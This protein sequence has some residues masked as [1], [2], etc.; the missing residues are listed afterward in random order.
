MAKKPTRAQERQRLL[1]EAAAVH[2]PSSCDVA[3]IGGGAAGLVAAITA[4]EAGAQTVVFEKD[5]SC[6]RRILA[7][8]NGRCN[9]A[10]IRLD[11]RRFN[12]P[13]FVEAVCGDRWLDDVLAFFRTCNMRWYLEGDRLYPQ[14]RQAASVRNVLLARARE[15]GVI[16]APAREVADVSYVDAG[17]Y[18]A[19][20]AFY[21]PLDTSGALTLPAARTVVLATGGEAFPF[22]GNLGL[23][24]THRQPVLCPL[25]CEASPLAALDGR[26]V[27]AQARL[28]KSGSF[29]PSW[30]ERGEVLFRDYGI[31]GIVTFDLSRRAE[32]G[33]LVELDL[34]PDVNAS[35][36]RQIVD[37][38]ARG[39]FTPGILDGLLDPAIA[40]LLERLAHERW[41]VAWPER[42]EA[43]S[44][45]DALMRLAKA[46]PLVVT[47]P[48]DP[49]QAQVTRG[50]L[51]N[52]QF[53]TA[54]LSSHEHPW[55]FACGEALDVDADCGGF[56][57][58]WAW[59]SG[60]VAGAAAAERARA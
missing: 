59:K 18:P 14:S 36:L 29:F 11:S 24:S 55:L 26:R 51:R 49:A 60:M 37:P 52:D 40:A 8:G 9:F 20:L 12:D 50:G 45:S 30:Q 22:I 10:N 25:A 7:T 23:H 42:K 21:E 4:A 27:H 54:T 32:P 41:H 28:T 1:E 3:I 44:D 16:L 39:S 5:L 34:M 58:S 33:D 15:A 38:F 48:A 56:N 31:S 53:D 47:G 57:L 13:V 19:E 43:S 2:V 17:L 35:E 6:G 46:L